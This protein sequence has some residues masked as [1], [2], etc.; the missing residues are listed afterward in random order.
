MGSSVRSPAYTF[1]VV[2][3]EHQISLFSGQQTG[4]RNFY[5]KDVVFWFKSEIAL[6]I[7]RVDETT[8]LCY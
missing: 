6:Q 1:N 5:N 3:C 4:N 8:T 2:A 7:R